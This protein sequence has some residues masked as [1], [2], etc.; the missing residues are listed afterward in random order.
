MTER[1]VSKETIRSVKMPKRGHVTIE[2]VSGLEEDPHL[3]GVAEVARKYVVKGNKATKMRQEE[4]G[5]KP[6]KI[7]WW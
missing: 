2:I 5:R 1:A 4:A 6:F 7:K 3:K